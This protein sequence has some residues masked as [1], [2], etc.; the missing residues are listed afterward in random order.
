MGSGIQ[1]YGNKSPFPGT[2]TSHHNSEKGTF[3]PFNAVFS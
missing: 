3:N 2:T 1:K